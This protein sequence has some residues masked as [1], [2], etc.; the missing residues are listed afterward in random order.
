MVLGFL[1][2][3]FVW[4]VFG[5]VFFFFLTTSQSAYLTVREFI[6]QSSIMGSLDIAASL[7]AGN[8][9]P[10]LSSADTSRADRSCLGQNLPKWAKVERA[11]VF[12]A[13]LEAFEEP[14]PKLVH[15]LKICD[16]AAFWIWL[17]DRASSKLSV[18][19]CLKTHLPYA[20]LYHFSIHCPEKW[21]LMKKRHTYC[22]SSHLNSLYEPSQQA[23]RCS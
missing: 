7:G 19:Q 5:F 9:V 16:P 22:L 10:H 3:F 8:V 1:C 4:L 21:V 11:P 23:H 2:G 18:W 12:G 20:L 6:T 15:F 17:R 13:V 14:E